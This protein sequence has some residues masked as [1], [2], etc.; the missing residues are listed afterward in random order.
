MPLFDVEGPDPDG[1]FFVVIVDADGDEP[2]R[3]F[4]SQSY[5]TAA[6]AHV[7]AERFNSAPENAPTE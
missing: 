6:A 3:T 4:L 2:Q 1:D 7:A 5:S